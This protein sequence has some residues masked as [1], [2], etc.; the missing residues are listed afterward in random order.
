MK[1]HKRDILEGKLRWKELHSLMDE[2]RKYA[3]NQVDLLDD[4]I[5][6]REKVD[7][8]KTKRKFK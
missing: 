1:P 5:D 6:S 8:T 3:A 4:T 2:G 7:C